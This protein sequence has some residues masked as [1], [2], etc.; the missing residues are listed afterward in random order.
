MVPGRL[1][2][3]WG[4]PSIRSAATALWNDASMAVDY[5]YVPHPHVEERKLKTPPKVREQAATANAFQRFNAKVG[6]S[7]TLVV[8]T[9]WCA[10]LFRLLV[11]VSAPSA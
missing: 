6:L 9:M 8:G 10:H 11:L 4:P 2:S 1:W 3:T 5:T 7:I